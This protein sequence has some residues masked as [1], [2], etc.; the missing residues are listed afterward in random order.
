MKILLVNKYLYRKGGAETYFIKLG[1]YLKSLGNEVEYFGMADERNCVG[2]RVGA[3]TENIDFHKKSLKHIFQKNY[4]LG[5]NGFL[6][7]ITKNC[8]D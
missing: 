3:Y 2:N 6:T 7:Y 8:L 4:C 5:R 1:E